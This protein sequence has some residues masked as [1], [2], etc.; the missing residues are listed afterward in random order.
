MTVHRAMVRNRGQRLDHR[1][2]RYFSSRHCE[3]AM[4]IANQA[5]VALVNARLYREARKVAVLEERARLA[6]EL[7]D[8]VSQA[9]YGMALSTQAAEEMLRTD[10]RR[11]AETLANVRILA[12]GALSEM[13]SLIFNLRPVTLEAE[14][15]SLA[16]SKLADAA[17]ASCNDVSLDLCPDEGLSLEVKENLYRICQEALWN[18]IKHARAKTIAIR[19]ERNQTHALLEVHDDGIGFDPEGSFPGHF[20]L[21]SMRERAAALGGTVEIESAR[22]RGARVRSRIPLVPQTIR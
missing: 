15:L 21:S 18:I 20:G 7:H 19:V 17:R 2:P 11:A 3:L 8:S 4:A 9:I 10:S 12:R 22:G 13:R 16:L 14:G 6:R 1:Q 5:A